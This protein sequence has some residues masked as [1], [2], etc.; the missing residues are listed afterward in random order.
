MAK[1]T[2]TLHNGTVVSIDGTPDEIQKILLACGGVTSKGIDKVPLPAMKHKSDRSV[3]EQDYVTQI[4]NQIKSCDAAE[5]I[6]KNIIDRTSQ[7]DKILLPLY[8]AHT[9]FK[10]EVCLQS[11]EISKITRELGIPV[12]QP[13]VSTRLST[14]AARYV[15]GDKV[16]KARKAVKYKINRRGLQYLLAVIQGKNDE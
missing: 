12:S 9:Y 16:R 10:G 15:M 8:I 13:N 4:V 11:G 7:V 6:E 1:A 2:C 14:T 5:K 3:I